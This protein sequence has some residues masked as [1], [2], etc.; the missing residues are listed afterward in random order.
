MNK[1]AE[2]EKKKNEIGWYRKMGKNAI[3]TYRRESSIN[4]VQR[5]SY[6]M[7][8][9]LRKDEEKGKKRE[10]LERDEKI[11]RNPYV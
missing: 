3:H 7:R 8:M 10:I 2:R 11:K 4:I 5:K 9:K 6:V 1:K